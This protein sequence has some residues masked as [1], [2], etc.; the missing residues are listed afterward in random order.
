MIISQYTHPTEQDEQ[1]KEYIRMRDDHKL[2]LRKVKQHILSFYLR[3]NYRF[4]GTANHWTQAH[5]KCLRALRPKPYD[6]NDRRVFLHD[7]LL[8]F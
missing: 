5:L 3:H 2:A 8:S 6:A 4:D 1:T 7:A